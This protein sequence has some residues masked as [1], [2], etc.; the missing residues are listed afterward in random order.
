MSILL[1]SGDEVDRSY[2][3]SWVVKLQ[4]D[5]EWSTILERLEEKE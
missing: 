3:S 4:L 1:I 2:V 5:I